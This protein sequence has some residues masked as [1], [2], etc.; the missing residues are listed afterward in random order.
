QRAIVRAFGRDTRDGRISI[1]T[2]Y[3][4]GRGQSW[5]TLESRFTSSATTTIT[6]YA[7]GDAVQ[8]GRTEHMAPGHGFDLP[9]RRMRVDWVSGIGAGVSY[10][11]V[12]DGP[13]Q[14]DCINGSMWSDPIG[15]IVDLHPGRTVTYRRHVVV[16]DGDTASMARAVSM[17]RRDATGQ[18]EG[19]VTSAGQAVA[20]AR[21][22]VATADED[23]L[24]GVA[25]A[26]AQG[27]FSIVLPPR[28]Y[29]LRAEASGRRSVTLA[30]TRIA[31][32]ATKRVAFEMAPQS[33]LRWSIRN[34]D[35]TPAPVRIGIFGIGKTPTPRFGPSF[36][37]D[38]AEN[39][40]FS[41]DGQG[42]RPL[43]PGQ[44]RVVASQGIEHELFDKR[45]TIDEGA[46]V[47]VEGILRRAF[48]TPGLISTDLHQHA[49]PSYDS[50]VSLQD[51][52]IANVTEGVEVMVVS[53]HNTLVDYAPVIAQLG[54]TASVRS[55]V[56]VEATTHSVGHFNML[57][58]KPRP[59]HPRGGMV[60]PEGWTP[61]EIFDFTKRLAVPG[62]EPY[63]QI[64]HPRSGRTGYF[65]LMKLDAQGHAHDPRFSPHFDGVEVVSLGYPE[66]TGQAR[67]DWFALLSQGRRIT[68]TGTS[69]SHTLTRR[70]SG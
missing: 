21:I 27:L 6:G 53:D 51:R 25:N 66:E 46:E 4:L 24:V 54:L 57:P 31:A 55:I 59:A 50:G 26:D 28:R 60:D 17:L 48:E 44:Y 69:D 12:P 22:L 5:L 49:A 61:D 11:V 16:G 47:V 63:I 7:I 67:K 45:V 52:V 56:G 1:Q 68:A 41:V 19:R 29:R 43:P 3:I 14:F 13:G 38:G 37:A 10:A 20:D 36:R 64:N 39:F 9:G 65:S 42:R 23:R 70:P 35:G 15:V 58:L 62:I 33:R 8:W 40:V 2:D 30:E 32:K 18:L 34:K